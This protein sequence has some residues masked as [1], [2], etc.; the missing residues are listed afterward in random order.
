MPNYDWREFRDADPADRFPRRDDI[1]GVDQWVRL[2]AVIRDLIARAHTPDG[3][4]ALAQAF[5]QFIQA[6]GRLTPPTATAARV[7][8]S[9]Q[10]NDW[11]KAERVAWR[12]TEVGFEYWLDIHDPALGFANR[13]RLPLPIKAILIAAI[14]EMGLL[15]S[16]HIVAVQTPASQRSRWV[17]YEFGRAKQRVPVSRRSAS[18][19]RTGVTPDPNGDYLSLAFC[20]RTERDLKAWLGAQPGARRSATNTLW[21]RSSPPPPL[22]N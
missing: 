9:H 15:N 8:V 22:P 10:R 19:F 2:I 5:D 13:A 17:P 16:T 3:A 4:S 12:A 7:F 1:V 6:V 11:R 21:P 14:I 20:A 18:W